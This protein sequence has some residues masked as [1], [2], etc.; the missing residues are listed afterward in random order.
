MAKYPGITLAITPTKPEIECISF[1]GYIKSA[2]MER[3]TFGD[4]TREENIVSLGSESVDCSNTH[5]TAR[6]V[7]VS[8]PRS[9]MIREEKVVRTPLGKY[10]SSRA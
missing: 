5:C 7:S 1:G 4:P 2:R 3:R 9:L 8:N 10:C 6:L